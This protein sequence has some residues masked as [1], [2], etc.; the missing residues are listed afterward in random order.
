MTALAVGVPVVSGTAAADESDPIQTMAVDVPPVISANQ[1]GQIV[2]AI[3]PDEDTDKDPIELDKDDELVGFKLGPDEDG[4]EFEVGDVAHHADS[5]RYRLL[6]TGNMGV[7][8]DSSEVAEWFEPGEREAKL[9][10]I[11]E[12]GDAEEYMIAWGS[13]DV[14]V[15]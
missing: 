13:D 6:P 12:N 4:I 15:R 3:Y 8:F 7:F 14:T 1:N 11:G 5:V 9:S 10:A 2:T